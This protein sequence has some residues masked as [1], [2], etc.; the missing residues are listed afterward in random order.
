MKAWRIF[1]VGAIGAVAL[2][3]FH[4]YESALTGLVAIAIVVAMVFGFCVRP[5]KEVFSARTV[6]Q[7][8]EPHRHTHACSLS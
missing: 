5:R 3:S 7:G 2:F 4:A 6:V 1:L 8:Y